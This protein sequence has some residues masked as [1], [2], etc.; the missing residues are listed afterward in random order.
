ML[1]ASCGE[2]FTEPPA[3]ESDLALGLAFSLAGG[4]A[5]A[6][7][8]ADRVAVR[9]ADGDANLLDTTLPFAANGR[10]ARV[11]VSL[12]L[13]RVRGP[14]SLQV[15]VRRGPDALFRGETRFT[16]DPRQPV[17]ITLAPVIARIRMPS[18]AVQLTAIGA[19]T[20]LRAAAEF[21]TGDTVHEAT[22]VWTSPDAN[23]VLVTPDGTVTALQE[24]QAR[25]RASAG[26]VTGEDIV[27]VRQAA[28][29][30]VV[31][32]QTTVLAV[33]GAITLTA[34][35]TDENGNAVRSRTPTWTSSNNAIVSIDGNGRAR[36]IAVGTAI[37]RAEIDAA[38][39]SARIVVQPVVQAGPPDAPRNLTAALAGNLVTLNW[40]DAATTE[41]RIE[42]W[43]GNGQGGART[44][45]ASLPSNANTYRDSTAAA[46]GMYDYVVRACA[47]AACS[48]FT[49][50]L[51][52]YTLPAAPAGL[53]LVMLDSVT[54][55]LELRWQDRSGHETGFTIERRLDTGAFTNVGQAPA[56]ATRFPLTGVVGTNTHRVRACN[57]A[58]CSD[59]S[60]E[61]SVIIT[62]T[63]LPPATP[64]GLTLTVMDP[65]ARTVLLDWRDV[66]TNETGFVVE[67]RIDAGAYA[68][69]ARVGPNLTRAVITGLLGTNTHRVRACN[70]AGCSNP[71]NEAATT[72]APPT[73]PPPSVKTAPSQFFTELMGNVD[74]NGSGYEVWFEWGYTPDPTI[75]TPVRKGTT[76]QLWIEPL[77][78]LTPH[79]TVYYRVVARNASGTSRG[80]ILSFV[81]PT[82]NVVQGPAKVVCNSDPNGTL[83]PQPC[84]TNKNS[85]A[86][87]TS[88][89]GPSGIFQNPF[90][91]VGVTATDATGARVLLGYAAVT[92]TDNG[93]LRTYT[94]AFTWTPSYTQFRPGQ[95][96]LEVFAE[97]KS[98]GSI[99]VLRQTVTISVD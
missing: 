28:S 49:E 83:S 36:A 79:A 41:S 12:D 13:Q 88:A 43:R 64:T 93:I 86:I 40:V 94:Y 89:Q 18:P 99:L 68:E 17:E 78:G 73:L 23:I 98:G 39:D 5:S 72:F 70:T 32:P 59:F 1:T 26:G 97:T 82:M 74:G 31:A 45:A 77:Q 67:R 19:R 53:T 84:P 48:P 15:E 96:Q 60:N 85:T 52:V 3:A 27:R 6:F 80:A 71:S 76:A 34:T 69:V 92:V 7:D 33:G 22:L 57:G 44:L 29:R 21:A 91:R 65:V 37:L 47:D 38:R 95:V 8:R 24:G 2:V 87:V 4:Q 25:V 16:P 11:R 30:I 75:A 54:H 56:N 90:G 58:G 42:V 20:R 62:P 81:T 10:D 61:V 46:N 63:V 51:V 35:A 14:L 9:I 50:A 55:S 66:S